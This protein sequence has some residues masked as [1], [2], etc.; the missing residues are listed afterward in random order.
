MSVA[1]APSAPPN[2][3]GI[4]AA[5]IEKAFS[6]LLSVIVFFCLYSSLLIFQV[7]KTNLRLQI[8]L[9]LTVKTSVSKQPQTSPPTLTGELRIIPET[10]SVKTQ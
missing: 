3:T 6:P 5:I 8:N 10:P 2:F 9:F 4:P 7:S 1:I